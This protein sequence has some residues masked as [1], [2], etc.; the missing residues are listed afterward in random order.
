MKQRDEDLAREIELLK[1]RLEE[2]ELLA[3]GRGFPSIFHFKHTHTPV[4][5]K[6]KPT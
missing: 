6:A 4:D 3:K 1:H 2:V 5:V